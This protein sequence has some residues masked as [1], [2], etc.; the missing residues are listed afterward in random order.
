MNQEPT[1]QPVDERWIK[2]RLYSTL[3]FLSN[4][5]V[6]QDRKVV[7]AK[8]EVRSRKLFVGIKLVASKSWSERGRNVYTAAAN[9]TVTDGTRMKL[10][11][12]HKR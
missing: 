2:R 6:A 4:F 3:T 5:P 9:K 1:Y 7:I 8:L 11:I 10:G 12:F